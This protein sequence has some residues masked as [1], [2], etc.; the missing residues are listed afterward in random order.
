MFPL[1][2][3]Y[4]AVNLHMEIEFQN[5]YI[6]RLGLDKAVTSVLVYEELQM[7]SPITQPLHGHDYKISMEGPV[8]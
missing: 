2:V 5:V 1:Y 6:T 7:H 3:Q 8:I 4:R